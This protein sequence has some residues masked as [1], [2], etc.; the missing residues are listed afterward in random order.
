MDTRFELE[1][2]PSRMRR[3]SAIFKLRES[4]TQR[5][6]SARNI[7]ESLRLLRLALTHAVDATGGD[8][9]NSRPRRALNPWSEAERVE[10]DQPPP[11]ETRRAALSYRFRSMELRGIELLTS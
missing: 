2:Y 3:R 9:V 11:H 8:R 7:L 5:S 4:S 1:A 6:F 10:F